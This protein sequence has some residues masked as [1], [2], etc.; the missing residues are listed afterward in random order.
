MG[1][2]KKYAAS[3]RDHCARSPGLRF[4]SAAEELL[5]P[6]LNRVAGVGDVLS[7]TVGRVAADAHNGQEG[8]G[9]E[10]KNEPL[11]QRN[12][13][14]FHDV[15]IDREHARALWGVHPTTLFAAADVK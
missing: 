3:Q 6:S 1:L 15:I 12:L 4:L 10:E 11:N 14:S 2:T 9:K 13:M 7:E 8:G 5:G